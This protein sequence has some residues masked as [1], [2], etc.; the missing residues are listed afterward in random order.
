MMKQEGMSFYRLFDS[1]NNWHETKKKTFSNKLLYN[2]WEIAVLLI[3]F[4]VLLPQPTE[5]NY[6]CLKKNNIHPTFEQRPLDLPPISNLIPPLW[7]D[8]DVFSAFQRI[9][10]LY[11][12]LGLLLGII[13]YQNNNVWWTIGSLVTLWSALSAHSRF[14]I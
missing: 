1:E 3:L 2:I 10:S 12:V 5:K 8:A 11:W 4:T 13:N 7:Q 9:W 14:L 6:V